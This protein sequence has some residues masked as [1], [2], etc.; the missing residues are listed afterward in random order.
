[1][2]PRTQLADLQRRPEASR[3]G[4]Y[5]LVGMDSDNSTR[6]VVYIGEGDNI[7]TRLQK[8][9]TD[10]VKD[11]WNDVVL[12]VSKDD[13]LTKAHARYLEA[14]LIKRALN[15]KQAL[16]INQQAGPGGNLP[17]ADIAEMEEMLEHMYLLLGI[18]GVRAFHAPRVVRGETKSNKRAPKFEYTI[19][20]LTAHC[21][22]QDGEFVVLAGSYARTEVGESLPPAGRA[23]RTELL[24]SGV[25][26]QT[27]KGLRFTQDYPFKSP[28]AAGRII[29]GFPVNGRLAWRHVGTGKTFGEWEQSQLEVTD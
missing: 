28:S 23:E 11:F 18:L 2:A 22:L 24:E 4:V 1:M 9:D 13:N 15:A 17:E 16:V 29:A 3:T 10:Q 14:Q 6:E 20:G 12:F 26:E 19:A 27:P 5:I 25:L 21:H 8:H 7:F